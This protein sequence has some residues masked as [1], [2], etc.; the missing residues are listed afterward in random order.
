MRTLF[1]KKNILFLALTSVLLFS[2]KKDDDDETLNGKPENL[3]DKE[4]VALNDKYGITAI[5]PVDQW[6]NTYMDT[7]PT[8]P[9]KYFDEI[10]Y[11]AILASYLNDNAQTE[12]GGEPKY[13][14]TIY[15]MRFHNTFDDQASCDEFIKKYKELCYD[16]VMG[17]FYTDI[18]QKADT[19][20]GK[21]N[22]KATHYVAKR[23]LNVTDGIEDIYFMYKK[24]RLY[25]VL[26]KIDDERI[27]SSFQKCLDIL[28]T[29]SIK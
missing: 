28:P 16:N 4:H 9:D 25:G 27:E 12:E 6:T 23:G 15:F 21:G 2:C 13:L 14:T 20:I 18:T 3:V 11:N 5:F 19:T 8:N 29:I 1:S 22:Y 10:R 7:M 17:A 26:I 24:P